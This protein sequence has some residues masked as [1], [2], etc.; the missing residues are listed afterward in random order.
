MPRL[1]AGI[2]FAI[3]IAGLG[4][5]IF[6][7]MLGGAA[8]LASPAARAEEPRA[9]ID[10]VGEVKRLELLADAPAGASK[11]VLRVHD[12]SAQGFKLDFELPA[13]LQSTVDVAGEAYDVLAIDEGG[14]EGVAGAP[15]VPTFARLIQL[16][17]LGGA[18]IEVLAVET[19]ELPGYRL[20]PMQPGDPAPF[21]RDPAAYLHA[22]YPA[23]EQV[24][25][26]E[27]AIL[28]DLRVVPVL[29]RPVRFDA[30][31]GKIEVARRIEV[32]VTFGGDDARNLKRS[33][34]ATIPASY[35]EL[36]HNLVVNYRGPR[37]DQQVGLGSY[38]IICPN[39]S[40]ILTALQP[41]INWRR[42]KGMNVYVATTT[43]TGSSTT[44]IQAWLRNAYNAWPAPPEYIA[45]VGDADASSSVRIPAWSYAGGDTDFP[46]VLLEGDDVLADAHVGRISARDLTQLATYV[47]KIVS[48]ESTPYMDETSWYT[49][50]CVVGD[51]SASGYT[52]VQIGQWLKTR[53]RANGYT[54]VDTVFTAPWV[55]QMSA[56]LTRGDTAF[57]YRG[58]AGMSTF[59][60]GDA[61]AVN[62]GRKMHFSSQITCGT[63]SFSQDTETVC[64][65]WIRSGTAAAPRG[66][67]GAIGASTLST[68]TRYNN[69]ATYG[70]WGGVYNEQLYTM[71]AALNRGKWELYVN[72]S[73]GDMSAVWNF[74]HWIN[75][76]GDPA[77]EVW[78]GVPQAISVSHPATLALG[79]NAVTVSVLQGGFPLAGATVCLYKAD[80]THVAG[81]TGADGTLE[82]PIAVTNAGNLDV[83]VTKHNC[84]PY[85]GTIA[86][87]QH[88][89]FAGYLTHTLD[90]DMV[91]S[92]S[93]NGDGVPNP[94]EH[95]EI[96]VEAQN[97][98]SQAV[99][100]ITGTLSCADPYVSVL[101]GAES[102]PDLQPG[103]AAWSADDFDI[104]IDGGAPNG[105][106]VLCDLDLSSAG[107]VWRSVIEVPILAGEFYHDATTLYGFGASVDPGETGEISVRLRNDGA[108]AG[109]AVTGQLV[110]HSSW[111]TVTDSLGSFGNIV[112][113][114]TGENTADQFALSTSVGCFEGHVA[115]MSVLL[116]SSS[117][118]RDTVDFTI[119]VGAKS[120]TDPTG[121][122]GYGYYAFD[123]TDTGY[124]DAPTYAWIEIDPRYGGQGVSAGLI[125]NADES[126]D[127]EVFPLPFA[128]R[129]YG[130]SF[131]TVTI[132]S[133]G[134]IAMGRTYLTNYNNWTIPGV[135]APPYMIAPKWDGLYQVGDDRV[136]YWADTAG[137]RFVV[138]WSRLRNDATG[139]TEN[140]E[141][142]LYDPAY[143]PTATGDGIILFQYQ[144]FSTGD[145]THHYWTTGIEN[146][147]QTDGVLYSFFNTY[148]GGAA[149]IASGR[150]IKFIPVPLTDW[151]SLTGA[152]HNATNGGTGIPQAAVTV[153]GRTLITTQED[154]TYFGNVP[155]G[156]YTVIVS[157]PSFASDTAEVVPI[158][159]DQVTTLDFSLA[160]I[161]GPAFSNTTDHGGTSDTT[162]PYE[163]LSTVIEYSTIEE[164]ALT[165]NIAGTGW[166]TVP[167]ESQ[168]GHLYRAEIPGAQYNSMIKYYLH[169]RDNGGNVSTDPPGAPGET[170]L[171]WVIPPYFEDDVEAGVGSWTHYVALS[172]YHD[173]WHRS[174]L[175]NHTAGGSWSWKMGDTSTGDYL[176]LDNGALQTEAFTLNGEAA[177]LKFWH[178]MEAEA[179]P[180]YPGEAYDGGLLEISVNGGAWTL[181]T[182]QGG[183]THAVRAGLNSPFPIGTPVF[184]GSFD[185]TQEELD[186]TGV[187][188]SVR[189]RFRFGSDGAIQKEGWYVDD[190]VV[191]T[192]L[193]GPSEAPPIERLP[194]RLALYQNA[195]N[196]FGR[197][198]AQTAIAFDLPRAT[199]VELVV[200]DV[201]GRLVETL[202]DRALPAGRHRVS[203]D[204]RDGQGRAIDSGVYFCLLRAGDE[205]L[206]RRMLLLR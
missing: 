30:A 49:R 72:Y 131:N 101:D 3:L 143:Y 197:A 46:Y 162:G 129:Y 51:P 59:D 47:E 142:I 130:E 93:G 169:G 17:D 48:Y 132:C 111:V 137:H 83:T 16:P 148:S 89:R 95:F 167:L 166:V 154:G 125:D 160:D 12:E 79:A 182:P 21:T 113:G 58:F 53:M 196:P 20:L 124:T 28:R 144:A 184:S 70:I 204:G 14:F 192:S 1:A 2:P 33:H 42:H 5:A 18:R 22:G 177:S 80:E 57:M 203:W 13:L 105:H 91:G 109:L 77:G 24:V 85:Q 32:R 180:V 178:W 185:W 23:V 112:I 55:S 73:V 81:L 168:G 201:G 65:A 172:G 156:S 159:A 108:A 107:D 62:N 188:G 150:A 171:F 52:C 176:P 88:N 69:C 50:G 126:G 98:G 7:A 190:I 151:G 153:V 25:I 135:G 9:D 138:Q 92:S 183:Y 40:G 26:G 202:V 43:E 84:R 56:A 82:L 161:H 35:D 54:E 114:S 145:F 67:I 186:L 128:F 10:P 147:N 103:T 97:F 136:Y 41:L 193:P 179:S 163:I 44:S 78:T 123:N 173:Q 31:A 134:W 27:P 36:Y 155:V 141:A 99:Q 189:V 117:G 76:I 194:A 195:P 110:S 139:A 71:G 175:R 86:L 8:L 63:N 140:F 165:Y 115:A 39:D 68:H 170:Y 146:G 60:A 75:L 104:A 4:Q 87:A 206:T 133:N 127:S 94:A 6:F 157:H 118:A 66:G 121:P 200:V 158:L 37:D 119:T 164:L 38:V 74:C 19:T 106:V 29:F 15:M 64:E 45:I 199:Q 102:F 96:A 187:S 174:T 191:M 34:A 100:G 181:V 61:R 122:D 149:T 152:V 205:A 120:S 116:Q 198:A 11:P 90:D